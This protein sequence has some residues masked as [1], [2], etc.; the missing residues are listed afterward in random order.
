MKLQITIDGKTYQAEVEV[1]DEAESPD[2]YPP[3]PPV[4]STAQP[5]PARWLT[6]QPTPWKSMLRTRSTTAARLRHW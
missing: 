1:L 3:Y 6:L 4:V 2:N 5:M